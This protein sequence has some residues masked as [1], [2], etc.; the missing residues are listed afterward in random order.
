MI[1]YFPN[2]HFG[3]SFKICQ[4]P[5]IIN[6]LPSLFPFPSNLI[7]SIALFIF[8][9]SRFWNTCHLCKKFAELC[10]ILIYRSPSSRACCWRLLLAIRDETYIDLKHPAPK[11]A[12]L[13]TSSSDWVFTGCNPAGYADL[14]SIVTGW[15]LVPWY[16]YHYESVVDTGMHTGMQDVCTMSY[17]YVWCI[18]IFTI[19]TVC[20]SVQSVLPV[21]KWIYT[22]RFRN[23]ESWNSK[24]RLGKKTQSNPPP[25]P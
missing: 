24:L 14:N 15:Y 1:E 7:S 22:R 9:P 16:H 5:S 3:A 23:R 13:L 8:R 17:S 18:P 19:T 25:P 20:N 10:D 2:Y 4:Q 21:R 6:S 11:L 12:C